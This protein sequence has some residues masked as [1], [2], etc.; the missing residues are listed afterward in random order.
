VAENQDKYVDLSF[1]AVDD[2]EV[3]DTETVIVTL[4]DSGGQAVADIADN[5]VNVSVLATDDTA[6]EDGKLAGTF[7]ISRDGHFGADLAVY[8]TLSGTATP[9]ADY[10]ALI[11]DG[12]HDYY[13]VII[14]AD[15]TTVNVTITP[16]NDELVEETET[17]SLTLIADQSPDGPVYNPPGNAGPAEAQITLQDLVAAPPTDSTRPSDAQLQAWLADIDNLDFDTRH[18]AQVNLQAAYEAHPSI[19]PVLDDALSNRVYRLEGENFLKNLLG[20]VRFRISGNT[21]VTS[22][23]FDVDGVPNWAIS[24]PGGI[25]QVY[26]GDGQHFMVALGDP[27]ILTTKL[28]AQNLIVTLSYQEMNAD[29]TVD[30]GAPQLTSRIA[31]DL[32]DVPF[33]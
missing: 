6:K 29:G 5:D 26:F 18:A 11:P 33:D 19:E 10:E 9:S 24:V 28:S 17:V 1:D 22:K 7:A 20:P 3:E 13:K 2:Q 27:I 30:V 23:R 32:V 21:I 8:F 16:M 31:F 12:N 14:P 15:D 25:P 4:D